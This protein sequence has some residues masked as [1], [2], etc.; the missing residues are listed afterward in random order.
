MTLF[1]WVSFTIFFL[2]YGRLRRIH[3]LLRKQVYG[4]ERQPKATD[5]GD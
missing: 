2:M 3:K 1:D 4:D 5:A